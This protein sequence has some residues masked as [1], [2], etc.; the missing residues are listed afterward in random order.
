MLES[1]NVEGIAMYIAE[2][3]CRNIVIMCGAGISTSAGIPDFRTPGTGLYDNL[4]KFHLPFAEAVF[5]MNYFRSKPHAFYE[6]AREMWPG[7]FQPTPTHYFI[8][9]LHD[10]GILLRCYSQNI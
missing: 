8:R 3:K 6:L 7:N 1:F 2:K 10:K 4:Q 5:E 9:L